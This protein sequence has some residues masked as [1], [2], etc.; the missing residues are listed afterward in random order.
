MSFDVYVERTQ[1]PSPEARQRVAS[2]IAER[3]GVPRGELLARLEAGRFRAKV[4][5][6]RVKALQF[7]AELEALGAVCSVVAQDK[8]AARA[9]PKPAVDSTMLA[10]GAV[11]PAQRAP[12]ATAQTMAAVPMPTRAPIPRDA[13]PSAADVVGRGSTGKS[14]SVGTGTKP[15]MNSTANPSTTGLQAAFQ[16]SNESQE[17]GALGSS[18]DVGNLSLATLDGADDA[19]LLEM[20]TPAN[21]LPASIAPIKGAPT[22]ITPQNPF[23]PPPEGGPNGEAELS[24][25]VVSLPKPKEPPP[26]APTAQ[27]PAVN[28]AEG[29]DVSTLAAPAAEEPKKQKKP[30]APGVPLDVR[31]RMILERVRAFFEN[32]LGKPRPRFALGASLA[33]LLAFLPMHVFASAWEGLSY[34]GA[35]EQLQKDYLGAIDQGRDAMLGLKEAAIIDLQGSRRFIVFGS[36]LFW[37][38]CTGALLFLWEKKLNLEPVRAFLASKKWT[39]PARPVAAA[40]PEEPTAGDSN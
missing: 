26:R 16:G 21:F 25:A 13:M 3:F 8:G 27:R 31:A 40:A 20:P 30:R 7:A 10:V 36:L 39:P 5:V 28:F 29:T 19:D 17:L 12:M 33:V 1:D 32:A 23:A 35:E 2:A 4:G 38:A 6:E 11:A 24:L 34:G 14:L 37:L 18:M 9:A 22:L 15:A